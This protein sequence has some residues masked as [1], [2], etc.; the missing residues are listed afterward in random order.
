QQGHLGDKT[1]RSSTS[2]TYC[3]PIGIGA[4]LFSFPSFLFEVS[5]IFK[6]RQFQMKQTYPNIFSM[7][8]FIVPLQEAKQKTDFY[9]FQPRI[10]T[11]M[12]L[13]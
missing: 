10:Q 3:D 6:K 5:T 2:L 11:G 4:S 1:S 13:C 9:D 7:P 8:I 12:G